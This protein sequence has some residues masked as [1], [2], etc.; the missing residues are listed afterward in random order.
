MGTVLA[1]SQPVRNFTRW[2][3]QLWDRA[4]GFWGSRVGYI[5]PFL[6]FKEENTLSCLSDAPPWEI[7]PEQKRVEEYA[8]DGVK[9]RASLLLCLLGGQAHWPSRLLNRKEGHVDGCEETNP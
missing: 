1:R 9:P 5:L 6:S 8:G 2:A 3:T 7:Q 4:Q